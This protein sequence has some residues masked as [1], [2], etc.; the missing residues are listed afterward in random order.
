MQ[1]NV[2]YT[3]I[4]YPSEA[5][6]AEEEDIHAA[7]LVLSPQP[8]PPPPPQDHH[9]NRHTTAKRHSLLDLQLQLRE[10]MLN[11]VHRLLSCRALRAEFPRERYA[12]RL[13]TGHEAQT[14]RTTG[15]EGHF[16]GLA[17]SRCVTCPHR[18]TPHGPEAAAAA[19]A[20]QLN[21]K[22]DSSPSRTT[23]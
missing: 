19:A 15:G 17:G 20:S 8:P 4:T 13:P 16:A 21:L 9:R 18:M 22:A 7:I 14:K 11:C 10:H 6:D 5:A 3:L 2:N 12:V 23:T 1:G